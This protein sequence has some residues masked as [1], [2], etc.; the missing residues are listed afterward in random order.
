M[1][2]C[3]S[4]RC[5]V[6]LCSNW[7][8]PCRSW[9]GRRNP[10]NPTLWIRHPFV[11]DYHWHSSAHI[12]WT[13]GNDFRLWG[14]RFFQFFRHG[15]IPKPYDN[16]ILP[17]YI[18]ADEAFSHNSNTNTFTPQ[19][20]IPRLRHIQPHSVTSTTTRHVTTLRIDTSE[21]SISRYP[22]FGSRPCTSN[23][24]YYRSLLRCSRTSIKTL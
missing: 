15:S 2:W 18:G 3:S 6:I 20:Q 24:Q 16:I 19:H 4:M 21:A 8:Y 10:T 5:H 7:S 11:K 13:D 22:K 12:P 17:L 9:C 1:V 14:Q 23:R